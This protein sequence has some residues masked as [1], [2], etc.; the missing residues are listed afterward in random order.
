MKS[1]WNYGKIPWNIRSM[2][3]KQFSFLYK[4]NIKLMFLEL[5]SQCNHFV[6]LSGYKWILKEFD[7]L[8]KAFRVNF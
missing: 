8:F 1:N 3:W 5:S 6:F 7:L 4:N 2:L